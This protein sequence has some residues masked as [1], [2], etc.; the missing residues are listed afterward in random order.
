MCSFLSSGSSGSARRR[1]TTR[2]TCS[3]MRSTRTGSRAR[4]RRLSL[5]TSATFRGDGPLACLTL[6][7]LEETVSLRSPPCKLVLW[8]AERVL[9]A[10][11]EACMHK[12]PPR[13]H[14]RP[15]MPLS[16][17]HS[18]PRDARHTHH[19]TLCVSN[20]ANP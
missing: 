12:C 6:L 16:P 20:L 15:N 9:H 18:P 17:A 4:Q 14:P 2:H 7:M 1:C 13:H 11:T 8:T 19:D 3:A 5:G 10:H